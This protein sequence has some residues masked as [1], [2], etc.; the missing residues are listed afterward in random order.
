MVCKHFDCNSS[1][2]MVLSVSDKDRRLMCRLDIC[3]FSFSFFFFYS[4]IWVVW[5]LKIYHY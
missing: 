2:L 1:A 3:V 5:E 4:I